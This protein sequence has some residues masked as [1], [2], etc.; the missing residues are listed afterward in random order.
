MQKLS[1]GKTLSWP[2][3]FVQRVH[4]DINYLDYVSLRGHNY[5]LALI[6]RATCYV[7]TYVMRALSGSEVIEALKKI[8]LDSGQLTSKV[9]T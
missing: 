9:F 7:W 3:K 5:L 2:T 4:M 1:K 6:D 8:C